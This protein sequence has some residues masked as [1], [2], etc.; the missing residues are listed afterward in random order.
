[1]GLTLSIYV[2]I[3]SQKG[4]HSSLGGSNLKYKT[5]LIVKFSAIKLIL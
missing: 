5:Q 2:L 3:S 1:M 4:E